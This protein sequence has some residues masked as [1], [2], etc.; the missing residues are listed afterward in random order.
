MLRAVVLALSVASP[1]LADFET[2]RAPGTVAETMDALE[3]AVEAAGA[4]VF[5]RVDHA[6]GA[7]AEGM[8]LPE[9]QLLIFGNP[10]LGTPV[11]QDDIRAGLM[12]PLRVLV[13]DMGGR[14][15]IVWEAPQEMFD[16][17]PLDEDA[18]H[19]VAIEKA[20]DRLTGAAAQ[21]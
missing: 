16:D 10:A 1:A 4:T 11:M 15:Q 19:V 17:L 18:P 7:R 6:A 12:L 14:T 3:A 9:A 5:A 8:E 20:L 2:R 13:H 21:R